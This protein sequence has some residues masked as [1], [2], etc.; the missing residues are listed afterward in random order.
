MF[1]AFGP[2]AS[3]TATFPPR[4]GVCCCSDRTEMISR[5]GRVRR[6]MA[7]RG[8]VPL[9]SGW[10]GVATSLATRPRVCAGGRSPPWGCGGWV[11]TGGGRGLS[12]EA[13]TSDKEPINGAVAL[14]LLAPPPSRPM[15]RRPSQAQHTVCSVACAPRGAHH[16]QCRTQHGPA[17]PTHAALLLLPLLSGFPS[18]CYIDMTCDGPGEQ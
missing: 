10:G 15:L 16:T 6:G 13:A 2:H 18:T 17:A 4:G 3:A 5:G 9:A 8:W 14:P 1:T 7:M 12:Q 11:Q